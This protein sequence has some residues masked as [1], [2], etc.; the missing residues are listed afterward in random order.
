MIIIDLLLNNKKKKK[1]YG[2]TVTV[3][4]EKNIENNSTP[5]HNTVKTCKRK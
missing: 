5:R 1:L 2:G 4:I 3:E